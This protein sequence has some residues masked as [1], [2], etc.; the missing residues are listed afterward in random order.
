[1]SRLVPPVTVA[2]PENQPLIEYIHDTAYTQE[3]LP[4]VSI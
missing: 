4:Q 1:M 2:N 3:D